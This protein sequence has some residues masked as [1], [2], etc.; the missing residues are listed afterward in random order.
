ML[1]AIILNGGISRLEGSAANNLNTFSSACHP[2]QLIEDIGYS[3]TVSAS[4]L[5]ELL[6]QFPKLKEQD[7]ALTLGVMSR[8][9]TTTPTDVSADDAGLPL[10]TTFPGANAPAGMP[11]TIATPTSWNVAV[12]VDTLKELYPKLNWPLVIKHLDHPGFLLLDQK[13][14]ALIMSIYRKATKEPFPLDVL[15]DDVWTNTT[16]MS[17]PRVLCV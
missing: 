1:F 11:D 4:A 2:S 12:F 6:G 9:H 15:F 7:V 10:C 8:T 5:K 3:S 16:G 17:V 14:L 13:G